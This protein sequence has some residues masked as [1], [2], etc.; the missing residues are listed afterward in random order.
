MERH[1]QHGGVLPEHGLCAVA[2][3]HVPVHDGDPTHA[4]RPLRMSDPDS[5]V[6]EEA[7][8]HAEV[9]ERMV[10]GRTHQGIRVVDDAVEH[11]VDRRDR[12]AGREG[13]DL[14]GAVAERRL[15]ARIPTP[16]LRELT[17]ALDVAGSVDEAELLDGRLPWRQHHEPVG[18]PGRVEE[19]L[20]PPLRGGTLRVLPRLE[21]AAGGKLRRA[22]A[23]VVPH[24][25][26]VPHEP[27]LPIDRHAVLPSA[28]WSVFRSE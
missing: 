27:R 22:R 8:A 23:G 19:V 25:P 20:E 26:L 13:G 7:E 1:R 6:R 2:V 5:H 18:Q 10:A 16:A 14:E 3:V 9:G 21:P 12:S 11:G 15:A 4:A 17:D 28:I 24:H